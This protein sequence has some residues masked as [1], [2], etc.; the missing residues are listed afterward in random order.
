VLTVLVI[1]IRTVN[2]VRTKYVGFEIGFV[3]RSDVRGSIILTANHMV[4]DME[5]GDKLYV[6]S[7]L[8]N[9]VRQLTTYVLHQHQWSDDAVLRVPQL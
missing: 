6:R 7:M 4:Q 5:P 8:L 9:G 3:I 2:S 1:R